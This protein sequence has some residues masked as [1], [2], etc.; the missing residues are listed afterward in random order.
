[1]T[2]APPRSRPSGREVAVTIDDLPATSVVHGDVESHRRI[3][4][5]LLQGLAAHRIPAIG[6]VN[7]CNLSRRA[8]L[9]PARVD[10]LRR[11]LDAGLELG[12]HGYAHLDLHRVSVAEFEADVVRGE[13]VT[14]ALLEERGLRLRY[15]RHPFLHTGTTLAD[16][17][18]V[19]GFLA[20]HGYEVAPVTIYTE[21]YMFAAAFDRAHQRRNPEAARAVAEAFVPY[22]E[23][24]LEFFEGLSQRLLGYELPQT[25]LLHAN[26]INAETID[27]MA[28]MITRRGYRFVSLEHALADPAY[29]VEDPYVRAHG[30]SWLQRWGLN[31]GLGREILDAEPRTPRFVVR[32]AE[33]RRID[34]SRR[35]LGLQ[36]RAGVRALKSA[37]KS[38]ARATGVMPPKRRK[39]AG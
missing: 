26:S 7:E 30:V 9:D 39:T 18:R 31:R 38:V 20:N 3:T 29:A 11:W 2:A 13:P 36:S 33:E 12:N 32:R 19:E 34:Q 22:I 27:E 5:R 37:V 4:E 8:G 15:F 24:K 28:G 23:S 35:W 1:M 16:K 17:R 25:L 6:F 10:L 14:R 21:D